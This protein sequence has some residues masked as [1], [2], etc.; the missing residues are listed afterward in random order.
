MSLTKHING[1]FPRLLEEL[2]IVHTYIHIHH[3]FQN[4]SVTHWFYSK[5]FFYILFVSNYFT[6]CYFF[7]YFF[8]HKYLKIFCLDIIREI[9]NVMKLFYD[10]W[11]RG[12]NNGS[13]IFARLSSDKLEVLLIF[14]NLLRI[15]SNTSGSG[16]GGRSSS[17][18]DQFDLKWPGLNGARAIKCTAVSNLVCERS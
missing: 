3:M 1:E 17:L 7:L 8:C 9:K 5:I 14:L 16:G 15:S 2:N 18:H 12:R 10:V 13:A 4:S 6:S 11:T